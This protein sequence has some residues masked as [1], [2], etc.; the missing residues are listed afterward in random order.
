M[1]KQNHDILVFALFLMSPDKFMELANMIEGVLEG[2]EEARVVHE[3]EDY[4]G[5]EL[6]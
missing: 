2:F 4:K 1:N 6:G 3:D 5:V